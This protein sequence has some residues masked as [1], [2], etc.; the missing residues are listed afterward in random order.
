MARVS[1]AIFA[2]CSGKNSTCEGFVPRSNFLLSMV[3]T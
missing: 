2:P 1:K 3:L